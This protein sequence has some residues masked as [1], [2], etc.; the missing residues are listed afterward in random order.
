MLVKLPCE[1]DAGRGFDFIS[2]FWVDDNHYFST[3]GATWYSSKTS[4]PWIE[5]GKEYDEK[6]DK[7][8]I[9]SLEELESEYEKYK[10]GE[11]SK[12]VGT[13]KFDF[14]NENLNIDITKYV[15]EVIENNKNYGL[16]LCFTPLYEKIESDILNSVNFFTDHTNTFFHPYVEV[17]YN[18][19]MMDNRSNMSS[20]NN[21]RLYLTVFNDGIPCNLDNIPTCSIEDVEME[22]KQ[23][24]K[25][26]YY[27]EISNEKVKLR[28][29]TTYYDTWSKIALNGEKLDDIEMEFYVNKKNKRINIGYVSSP[30][31]ETVPS[32]YG[33]N[34]AENINQDEIREIIVDFREKY[35][36]DKR[37]LIN[38]AEYRL[39]VKDGNRE[40]D[41]IQYQPIEIGNDINF[42]NIFAMDLIPNEY[43]IDIKI[44]NGREKKIYKN[45]LRFN[46]V[47]NITERYQ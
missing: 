1:F 39:Y 20:F 2:D 12:I 41:V 4:I 25:G 10:L 5:Y 45:V 18:E 9:Y 13:Q 32:I 38:N 8:G 36:T 37:H 17:I 26:V 23:S 11:E 40:L 29:D 22:V 35:S 14:G 24:T 15:L 42:F 21:E 7:G 30:N 44:P 46:V 27:A 28:E 47:S 33:I 43:F 3:D 19:Y 16:C 34:D 6:N 31:M